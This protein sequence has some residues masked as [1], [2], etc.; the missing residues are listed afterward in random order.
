MVLK[1][2]FFFGSTMFFMKKSQSVSSSNYTELRMSDQEIYLRVILDKKLYW[3]VYLENRKRKARRTVEKTWE[4][5][6]KRK[7]KFL[8]Q[9]KYG[10]CK[11]RLFHLIQNI[12]FFS[13]I[14]NNLFVHIVLKLTLNLIIFLVR[15]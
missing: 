9:K 6:S 15:S 13:D 10:C 14:K 12:I 4:V 2:F 7:K 3:K 5:H 11:R 1:I 8:L